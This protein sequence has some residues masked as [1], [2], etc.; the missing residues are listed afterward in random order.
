MSDHC[1]NCGLCCMHMGAPPFSITDY[2]NLPSDLKRS[3]DAFEDSPRRKWQYANG[4]SEGACSWLNL[5]T[6]RC[7][8][9]EHRPD[10]CREFEVG[11]SGCRALRESV[12]LTI[13]GLP[14]VDESEETA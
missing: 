13:E 6:G 12:G 8:H 10:V 11:N 7:K 9:Y 3:V 4:E 1:N 5:E 2:E 14:V